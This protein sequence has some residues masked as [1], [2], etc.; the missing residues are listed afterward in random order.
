ME[1]VCLISFSD[2]AD[3]QNVI[4]S[5]F[6]ELTKVMDAYTIGIVKPK[7]SIAP[8]TK[9]NFYFRCPERPGINKGTFRFKVLFEIVKTVRKEK[10]TCLYFESQHLWN[11]LVM[12][13]CHKC[14]KIVAV[15]DVVP[16]D[17]NRAMFLS[18]YVT[19]HMANQIVLRNKKY[20]YTLCEKYH[21]SIKK[22]KCIELWRYW[23]AETKVRYTGI[24]LCF[25]R[26]RKYKG[27]DLLLNIIRISPN[28]KFLIVGDP[29]SE[30]QGIVDKIKEYP[31][32]TVVDR[33]VTDR[34]MESFFAMA[35]W[36]ILPYSAAT[37]SGVIVDAYKYSRPIISFSVGAISEQVKNGVTGFLIKQ[38]D[39]VKFSNVLK[40]VSEL[41][42]SDIDKLSHSAYEFGRKKYSAEEAAKK[43]IKLFR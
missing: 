2:N 32:T 16:H 36:V 42:R 26:I 29:D 37:Q 27:F 35:D 1:K 38:G 4:Y 28:I 25:G 15:H 3:H 5:M 24:F 8:H 31:N 11:A 30:S 43:L 23:P 10:I 14:K 18:N 21:L 34:E 13:M 40:R 6:N 7:S 41:S 22:I 33:E 19:C 9:R 39:V 12:L 17:G 20:L